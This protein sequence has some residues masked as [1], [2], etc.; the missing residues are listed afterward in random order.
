MTLTQE[1]QILFYANSKGADQTRLRSLI[2]I[3]VIL[4]RINNLAADGF[5]LTRSETLKTDFLV[6]GPIY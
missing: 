3:I 4:K 1:N 2:S 5:S 6:A